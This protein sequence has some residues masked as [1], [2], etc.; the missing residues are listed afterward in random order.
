MIFNYAYRYAVD[1]NVS[2]PLFYLATIVLALIV[3]VAVRRDYILVNRFEF[4]ETEFSVHTLLGIRKTYAVSAYRW[5]PA[6]HKTVNF[7]EKAAS[8][9]FYVQDAKTKKNIRNYSW[10]GFA[11]EAFQA[12]SALYG[13]RGETDFKQ[14]DFGRA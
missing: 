5:V 6:L 12:V 9:S 7:P 3:F 10:S 11:T 2:S 8:L 1:W 4:S 13:Y 14:K